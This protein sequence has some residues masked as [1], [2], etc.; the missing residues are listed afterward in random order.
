MTR[1]PHPSYEPR[2]GTQ[3]NP[4]GPAMQTWTLEI[5][6]YDRMTVTANLAQ[7]SAPI[8]VD[9]KSIGYQTADASHCVED[10]MRLVCR[11]ATGNDLSEEEWDEDVSYEELD[12]DEDEEP[13]Q[14]RGRHWE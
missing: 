14:L 13:R 1:K 3:L 12:E 4:P 11:W 6:G 10:M 2:T 7:A 8:R 9:G 5:A